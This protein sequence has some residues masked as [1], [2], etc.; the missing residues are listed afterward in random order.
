[1]IPKYVEKMLQRR[2]NLA[3][4]LMDACIEVDRYCE[5]IGIDSTEKAN[6]I[7]INNDAMIYCEP[8]TAYDLTRNEI[9]KVLN[10]GKQK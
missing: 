2:R 10:E 3:V 9:E 7:G 8:Y 5:K 1:M 6:E 4:K